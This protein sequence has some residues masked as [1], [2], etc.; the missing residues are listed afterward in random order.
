MNTYEKILSEFDDEDL[1]ILETELKSSADGL[2]QDGVIAI[3]KKIDTIKEK[4]CILAEE[5]GHHFKTYGNIQKLDTTENIKQ[6]YKARLYA[7]EK[8]VS[9]DKLALYLKK[10]I[11]TIYELSDVLDV[12]EEFLL[13]ALKTYKSKYGTNIINTKYG[14]LVFVPNI[15]LYDNL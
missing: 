1:L 4:T 15:I 8:L 9:L 3:N 10:G 6:E 11:N 2:Y 5:L 14:K 13:E 12:T 7:Y